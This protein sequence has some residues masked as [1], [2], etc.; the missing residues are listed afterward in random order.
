MLDVRVSVTVQSG[1]VGL[2]DRFIRLVGRHLL[3][4]L[5]K[6]GIGIEVIV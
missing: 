6:S 1:A 4:V 2:G 3:H 5:W